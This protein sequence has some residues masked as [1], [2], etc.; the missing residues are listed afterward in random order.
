MKSEKH[1]FVQSAM[2]PF[3]LPNIRDGHGVILEINR[4]TSSYFLKCSLSIFFQIE[5]AY[6]EGNKSLSNWDVFTHLPGDATIISQSL[7][8]I[9]IVNT[10]HAFYN[11]RVSSV[12]W[13]CRISLARHN[14]I[15]ILGSFFRKRTDTQ[16][17]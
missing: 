1:K 17:I 10:K 7:F 15:N 11:M 3:P 4:N 9:S 16:P 6:L 2:V 14:T 8:F 12:A 13:F 5:G